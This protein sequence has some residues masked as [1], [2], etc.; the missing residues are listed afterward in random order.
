MNVLDLF[1]GGCGGWSLGL[2]R[3]GFRTVAACE[4]DP[5]RRAVFA[6]NFPGVRLFADIRE[7]G[8]RHVAD[9]GP[10]DVVAGS[11]PCQEF[12]TANTKGRGLDS[13]RGS[14]FL[15][16][17]RLVRELRP[18]WALAENVPGIRARGYDRI[19]DAL[20]AAGYAVWPLVVGA[21]HAG[22]PHRRNRAWIVAR[23]H[24]ADVADPEE[25]GR[26]SRRP[27]RFDSGAAGEREQ[28]FSPTD[29]STVQR[30]AVAGR[31]SDRADARP[32]P[33]A[34]KARLEIG[35]GVG[36]D[37]GPELSPVE[38]AITER[39]GPLADWNGGI[40]GRVGVAHGLPKGV[41]RPALAAYG[42]SV[43][44]QITEAIGRAILAVEG[45]RR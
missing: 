5:W 8:A 36:G 6:R 27:G 26:G 37:D 16:F 41:A 7:L 32:A 24:G 34:D 45:V 3:A 13:E 18:R 39:C 12:S 10:I 2:H 38:R 22:A 44:P 14:L 40:A 21:W 1:S 35:R 30:P 9:L 20:E 4:I 23:R 15:E 42:D 25:Y 33:D 19:H 43:V 11:P 29:A 17:V 31:Q 28:A